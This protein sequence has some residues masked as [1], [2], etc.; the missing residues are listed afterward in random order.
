M[1]LA[2]IHSNRLVLSD[3]FN[4]T[5]VLTKNGVALATVT[6][7][8]GGLLAVNNL[9]DVQS[10]SISR[11]NLGLG[12]AAVE[13]SS[14]L[15]HTDNIF[16]PTHMGYDK[17]MSVA[18]DALRGQFLES[19]NGL[20]LITASAAN[21]GRA[22]TRANTSQ[23]W[24]PSVAL[25]TMNLN[26]ACLYNDS[27]TDWVLGNDATGPTTWRRYDLANAG[28][29]NLTISGTQPTTLTAPKFYNPNT[30]L[31]M[32]LDGV[33][34]TTILQYTISGTT[35]T[36]ANLDI[37]LSAAP[38][39]AIMLF[40]DATNI[41]ILDIVSSQIVAKRYN[42]TGTLLDSTILCVSLGANAFIV[43]RDNN[44]HMIGR[45]NGSGGGYHNTAYRLVLPN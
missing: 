10:A 33:S 2:T 13:D 24:K 12:S 7:I 23:P 44:L 29:N 14:D 37:T 31:I 5:G 34:A 18:T 39:N 43:G 38:T 16:V 32:S 20:T 22:L 45:S 11:T 40:A 21:A 26:G 4:F 6:D 30:S 1:S 28:N 19:T 35:I 42:L 9:S 25:G 3:P 15:V 17:F 41:I 8:A 36:N 27:G